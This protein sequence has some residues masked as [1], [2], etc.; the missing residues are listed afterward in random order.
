MEQPVLL[1]KLRRAVM[2]GP[3]EETEFSS[4]PGL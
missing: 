1:V 4:T 2:I 3:T